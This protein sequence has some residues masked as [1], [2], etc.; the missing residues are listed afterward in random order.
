[1]S[2][3]IYNTGFPIILEGYSDS[4]CISDVDEIKTQVDMYS[5]LVVMLFHESHA[6]RSS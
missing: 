2:Y 3:G 4:N 5:L 1:M 6:R